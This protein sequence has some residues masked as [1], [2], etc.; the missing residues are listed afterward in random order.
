MNGEAKR[1]TNFNWIK[2]RADCSLAQIFKQLELGATNDVDA[3][4][5]Q[6]KPEDHHTFSISTDYGRF[7]VT[8]KSRSVLPVSVDFSLEGEE[9]VVSTGNEIILTATIMLNNEGRCVLK[10]DG[11]E[12]EQWQVRRMAFEDLFF[13]KGS[14]PMPMAG[15]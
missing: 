8:R 7:S 5:E 13:G 14:S 12:L 10:V 9:I 2:A 15:R 3:A 6:R 11:E 4:N 1:V